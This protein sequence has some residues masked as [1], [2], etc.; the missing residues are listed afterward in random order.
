[1]T[2]PSYPCGAAHRSVTATPTFQALSM[3]RGYK[4]AARDVWG[5]LVCML[6][7]TSSI[8]SSEAKVPGLL[9]Y[10]PALSTNSVSSEVHVTRKPYFSNVLT[11]GY[12]PGIISGYRTAQE[13]VRTV[14]KRKISPISVISS[15]VADQP[16]VSTSL[17]VRKTKLKHKNKLRNKSQ[18]DPK[19]KS[20]FLSHLI[21][22]SRPKYSEK[23]AFKGK[24]TRYRPA[25]SSRANHR[26]KHKRREIF[27]PENLQGN[28]T[29]DEKPFSSS[30]LELPRK[31]KAA[32]EASKLDQE[33]EGSSRKDLGVEADVKKVTYHV[34]GDSGYVAEVTY[35]GQARYPGES[36]ST[37]EPETTYE[38]V[39]TYELAA[40]YRP[41]ADYKPAI[42]YQSV[43]SNKRATTY[44]P[45][46]YKTAT[47]YK[48]ATIYKPVAPYMS[49]PS[50]KLASPYE[51]ASSY[52]PAPT[53][54]PTRSNESVSTYKPTPFYRSTTTYKPTP[55]S[56]STATYKPIPSS[57]STT[58][59]KPTLSDKP[60][61]TYTPAITYKPISFYNPVRTHKP[62]TT[63]RPTSQISRKGQ[64][65]NP[66][67]RP[68]Y[69]LTRT[70]KPYL[71]ESTKN[72]KT[73]H[74]TYLTPRPI[75]NPKKGSSYV[76]ATTYRPTFPIGLRITR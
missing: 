65:Q 69:T 28:S 8:V 52:K 56:R 39:S 53:Y 43:P 33:S 1:M 12:K 51:A 61:P 37:Y 60:V 71:P 38:T 24:I 64:A 57:R 3:R 55:S 34:D 17:A 45:E 10:L 35:E 27:G 11:P 59:Y 6:L 29:S 7:L 2:P 15:V 73:E 18:W 13:P 40:A 49:V 16:I 22:K 9:T 72:S 19:Y 21:H 25:I 36:V 32:Q 70:Y 20:K 5:V 50:N 30:N 68:T 46:T 63:Y 41:A 74:S 62:V 23:T 58:T 31:D 4:K 75:A 44:R 54:K 47:T 48:P 67:H 26:L 14:Y 42:T 76:P 66:P